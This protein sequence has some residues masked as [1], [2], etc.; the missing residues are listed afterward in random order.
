MI[1]GDFLE[2]QNSIFDPSHSQRSGTNYTSSTSNNSNF[3]IGVGT[4]TGTG[5]GTEN[6]V[7]NGSKNK[8]IK[9]KTVNVISKSLPLGVNG[10]MGIHLNENSKECSMM[11]VLEKLRRNRGDKQIW[12]DDKIRN[13][14]KTR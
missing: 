10:Y 2:F 1:G 5:T 12:T 4:G 7:V 13:L 8:K 9:S 11:E 6:V 14:T 3:G